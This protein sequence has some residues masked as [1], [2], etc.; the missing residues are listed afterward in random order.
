[1]GA[2]KR[3]IGATPID[4]INARLASAREYLDVVGWARGTHGEP[5]TPTDLVGA[6]RYC[7]EPDGYERVAARL[8]SMRGFDTAWNDLQAQNIFEVKQ[9]LEARFEEGDVEAAYGENAV[10]VV[11]VMR[12][13]TM[14]GPDVMHALSLTIGPADSH[15]IY[16]LVERTGAAN[17]AYEDVHLT[18]MSWGCRDRKVWLLCDALV[19]H[20][21][22]FPALDDRVAVILAPVAEKLGL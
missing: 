2:F 14:A 16:S 22:A 6:L 5:G 1:M 3:K 10:L 12:L 15:A 17:P 4:R 21:L 13:L 8:L 7:A 19:A 20:S 9:A 11:G 18:A